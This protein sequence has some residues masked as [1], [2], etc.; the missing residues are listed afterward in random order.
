MF[1]EPALVKALDLLGM[2]RTLT[3]AFA[4]TAVALPSLKFPGQAVAGKF[5]TNFI[6][7]SI[8]GV[9]VVARM[10]AKTKANA[11]SVNLLSFS[12]M[13]T[14]QHLSHGGGDRLAAPRQL[15]LIVR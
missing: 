7:L 3:F 9:K 1:D 4:K 8:L 15:L 10:D 12:F 11:M 14:P 5:C 6:A 2:E 13:L